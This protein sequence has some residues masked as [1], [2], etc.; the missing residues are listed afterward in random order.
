MTR[1]LM[2][3]AWYSL[4]AGLPALVLPEVGATQQVVTQRTLRPRFLI[5]ATSRGQPP[6][7]TDAARVDVLRRKVVLD[8]V[9]VRL[10][11][12]LQAIAR[13]AGAQLVY[14]ESVLPLDSLVRFRSDGITVAAALTELLLGSSVDVLISNAKQ[15]VLTRRAARPPIVGS[16]A[17]RVTDNASGRGLPLVDVLL[18]GTQQRTTTDTN[19]WYRLAEL[20]PGTYTLVAR[21]LGY[22][23]Q[24]R[25]VAVRA[26]REDTVDVALEPVAARLEE[27]VT[28]ATGQQRRRDLGNAITT[29][30][31]DSVL[32]RAPIKNLTD[33]LANRVPGLT[34]QRTTGAPGDPSK[35]RLRGLGSA[36][37]SNDPVFIVDGVRVYAAQS[38][39]RSGNLTNLAPALG[40]SCAP[41]PCDAILGNYAPSPAPSPLDQID[42]NVIEKIEVFK[43]P[44]AATLYGAD[45]ANGVVV[46]TTKRGQSGP[47][48]WSAS[49][50]RGRTTSPG[51]YPTGYYRWGHDTLVVYDDPLTSFYCTLLVYSCTQD[52]LVQFQALNEPALTVLGRGTN[53]ALS[54]TA[55]GGAQA[56]SYS[57]TGSYGNE[58]GLLALPSYEIERFRTAH[59]RAPPDWMQRPLQYTNWSVSSAVTARLSQAMDVTILT[60]LTRSEQ[61]RTSLENQ[62]P[63]LAGTYVDTVNGTYYYPSVKYD[64]G[65]VQYN[66]SPSASSVLR[67]YY[68]KRTASTTTFTTGLQAQWRPRPW[69]N[70]SGQG[71]LNVIP[72][73][74]GLFLPAGIVH[75][76]DSG[77]V[78]V[79][80][81]RS[82][83]STFN[84]QGTLRKP[85]GWGFVFE[86][87][88]GTNLTTT[89]T[90]DLQ[91][92]ATGLI[93]GTSSL[94]GAT[95]IAAAQQG[96]NT[97]VYGWYLEPRIV[98]Q[99]IA[100]STGLRLDGGSA[101]GVRLT[102]SGGGGGLLG[103]LSLPKLNGSWVISEEPWFPFNTLFSSLRIRGAYGQ[104]QVQPGPTDRLRLYTGT[105]EQPTSELALT[106]L[107]NTALRPERS[108]E[109]EGGFDADLLASRVSVEL[110]AYRK[111]QV[112]ALMAMQVPPSVNGGGTVLTN[113]GNIRNT[114][115]EL[116]FDFTPVRLPL[117][118]WNMQ[119]H[120]SRNNNLLTKLGDG[121]APNKTQGLAEGYP[122][123]SRWAR[124]IL[125][126]ADQNGDSVLQ[127]GEIQVGD[128]LVYVGRLYPAYQSSLFTNVALFS[129]AVD[130]TAGFDYSAGQ[131]Q[132]DQTLR[133]NFVLT[134]ALVDA[135][136]P[137]SEQA[138]VWASTRVTN[139]TDYGL[140]Q[141]IST[142][143]FNSL[144]VN[145]RVPAGV[146]RLVGA[147]QL[148]IAVQGSNLGLHSTYR[149][150]DP[151][152]N[153]WSLGENIIDTGQLPVPRLWQVRIDMQF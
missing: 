39:A 80:T 25:K 92:S 18:E 82:L 106:S 115:L 117:V 11:D 131:T 38:D 130:I 142:F 83:V 16:V 15:I 43:G 52:S 74:D 128:S 1:L 86:T 89:T 71:G 23:K 28:T 152:V 150:K 99:R 100:I 97:S 123:G 54:L 47:T 29:I 104:A 22:A 3:V 79:G 48:R 17:G 67:D 5:P 132:V 34:A 94:S 59:N 33:L 37:R 101:Y 60:S 6:V 42:P 19:G 139:P 134:R 108:T 63:S 110:T 68:T 147:Q 8:A 88:L 77:T 112:D 26:D 65:Y 140:M 20:D 30:Q 102:R 12:A 124:P 75:V 14:V 145:Y 107:G 129:G 137:L 98:G 55:S 32:R 109:F 148:G 103:L 45:A 24:S 149:G 44:S 136:V 49:I 84:L 73:D 127:H 118:T 61:Q 58:T 53:T 27:L 2:C 13:Q 69:F 116:T 126:F 87:N 66:L 9:N 125:G 146:A 31:A 10:E 138:A 90:N 143:R 144:S 78:A 114:G 120:Y 76:N 72:R 122:V 153:A 51:R 7:E 70:A 95:N 105:S 119:L 36:L 111:L 93:P 133:T 96:S 50:T 57:L 35:L 85:V 121:V 56:L 113:I 21:R 81:G 4:C 46:I 41:P 141:E 40:S 151:N 64:F 91:S 135:S 62:L